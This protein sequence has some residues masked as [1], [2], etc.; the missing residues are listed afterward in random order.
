MIV[1]RGGGLA[2]CRLSF[3]LFMGPVFRHTGSF[4][5]PGFWLVVWVLVVGWAGGPVCCL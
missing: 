5:W 3:S 1:D 4:C 2:A